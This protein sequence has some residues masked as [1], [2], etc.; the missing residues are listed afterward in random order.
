MTIQAAID[1]IDDMKPNM[2]T[3]PQKIAW[4]SE[5]DSYIWREIIKTHEGVPAGVVFA[6]YD[7][8]TPM[9]TELLVP[10][11][12]TDVYDA[13]LSAQMD[14][15]NAES[16]KYA[17]NMVRFNNAWQTYGDYYNRHHMPIQMVRQFRL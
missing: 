15:K 16:G 5:V 12:Y 4:L 7:Q 3:V 14:L 9:D 17:Q 11:P 8:E 2:F 1:R 13:Y 6:G 10:E